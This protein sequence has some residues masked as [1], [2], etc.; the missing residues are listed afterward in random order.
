[1]HLA[2]LY[3]A[4]LDLPLNLLLK[5]ALCSAIAYKLIFG[6]VFTLGTFH[7]LVLVALDTA[8][9]EVDRAVRAAPDL[10]YAQSIVADDASL[11]VCQIDTFVI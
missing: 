1:M 9:A 3:P 7:E 2:F 5:Q 8:T 4:S 10:T 6:R 11:V